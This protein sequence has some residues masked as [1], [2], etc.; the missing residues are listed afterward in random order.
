ATW[1]RQRR[2]T[3]KRL[4]RRAAAAFSSFVGFTPFAGGVLGR[5]VV[6]GGGL[7]RCFAL[8]LLVTASGI[9]AEPCR[10]LQRGGIGI[11]FG[12]R[13]PRPYGAPPP[14]IPPTNEE[15]GGAPWQ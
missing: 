1:R 8:G 12:G 9:D 4:R 5:F 15:D 13:R 10:F 14:L 3:G 7:R 11:G 6:L 2:R